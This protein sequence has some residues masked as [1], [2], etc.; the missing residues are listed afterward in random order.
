MDAPLARAFIASLREAGLQPRFVRKTGTS[1]MNILAPAWQVPC[2][3]HGQ[4]ERSL[5]H[6]PRER[7]ALGDYGRSIGVLQGALERLAKSADLRV[8]TPN[9]VHPSR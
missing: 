2:L 4:G 1:D 9:T 3:T 5:D 6:T 7:L 8:R